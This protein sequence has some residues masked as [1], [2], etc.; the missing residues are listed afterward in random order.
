M[1][2]MEK[3]LQKLLRNRSHNKPETLLYINK[4][5]AISRNKILNKN[6]KNNNEKIPLTVTFNETT[7]DLRHITNKN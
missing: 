4:T 3:N 7:P 1:G 6:P 2:V 5:I